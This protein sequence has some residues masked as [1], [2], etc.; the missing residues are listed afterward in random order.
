MFDNQNILEQSSILLTLYLDIN[1]D[2]DS[3]EISCISM[4]QNDLILT[5]VPFDNL[6]WKVK[7]SYESLTRKC[8]SPHC[9]VGIKKE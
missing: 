2:C 9:S 3:L 8:S 4:K 5:L 7:Q 1:T 6:T